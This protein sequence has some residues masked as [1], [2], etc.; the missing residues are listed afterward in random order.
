MRRFVRRGL[1]LTTVAVL[2]LGLGGCGGF[3]FDTLEDWFGENEGDPLPGERISVLSLDDSLE[4]DPK[5]ADLPVKLPRPQANQN[6]TQ[7]GGAPDHANHH[8]AAS[9]ALGREWSATVGTESDSD[10]RMTAT[11]IVVDGRVFVMDVEAQ[12]SAFDAADGRRLWQTSLT[13]DEEDNTFGGGIAHGGDSVFVTTGFA[14]VIALD[15]DSGEERWRTN[16]PGPMRSAPTVSAG[17]VFVITIDNQVHALDAASGAS[18]WTHSGITETASLLGAASPAVTGDVLVVPFSSGELVA[19]RVENG[20]VVW[21]DNLSNIRRVDAISSLADIRG[22]PVVDRG[23]VFAVSHSGR[24][25]AIDLRTG[26]RVWDLELGGTQ[27]PWVA[28]NFVYVLSND[29]LLF[30][31]TRRGGRVRWVTPL[32]RFERPERSKGLINWVG[33]TLVSDRLIVASSRGEALS[34]S[35]YTGKYLG[36]IDLPGPVSIPPVVA[37]ETLFVL[38]DTA[39]LLAMR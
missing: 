34:I 23:L 18:L 25:V 9:G 28:G 16:M 17:R 39:D 29:S 1:R 37:N 32:Q 35:P 4:A 2:A 19:L 5:I 22:L 26:T 33:P 3:S 31:I 11:P 6:W 15:Q 10:R 38:T 30:C 13:P 27:T 20:R 24:M 12:V 36:M 8:L 7:S 21:G 14:Q